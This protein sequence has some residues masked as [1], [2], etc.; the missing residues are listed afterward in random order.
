MRAA[1][2]CLS[3]AGPVSRIRYRNVCPRLTMFEP[4]TLFGIAGRHHIYTTYLHADVDR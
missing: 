2:V 4:S 1:R 3:G